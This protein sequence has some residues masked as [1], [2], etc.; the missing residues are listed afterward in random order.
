MP[1]IIYHRPARVYPERL[2]SKEIQIVAPPSPTAMQ[3]GPMAWLAL[4]IPFLGSFS[5]IIFVLIYHNYLILIGAGLMIVAS[6]GGGILMN[7]QQRRLQKRQ[8]AQQ[9]QRYK[10]YID[11]NK[12]E[13]VDLVQRQRATQYRLHPPP[14]ELVSVINRREQLWERRYNDEDFLNI[15]IGTGV[16]PLCQPLRLDTGSNPMAEF[17][18]ELLNQARQLVASYENIQNMPISIPLRSLGVLAISGNRT[19]THPLTRAM[20][21]QI[22]TFA[23][24]EDA[25]ILMYFSKDDNQEWEWLKWLPHTRRLNQVKQEHRNKATPLCMLAHNTDDFRQLLETQVVPEIDRRRKLMGGNNNTEVA[26][27]RPHFI[28][29][30]DD[31]TAGGPVG[32]ISALSDMLR[33][34]SHLGVSLIYLVPDRSDEPAFVQGRIMVTAAGW[35]TYS[36]AAYGGEVKDF[37]QPDTLTPAAGTDV[38]RA[39]TPI[40]L[41]DQRNQQDLAREVR[42]LDLLNIE[43]PDTL[44]SGFNWQPHSRQDVLR[45]PIGMSA[46]G[47]PLMLDIKESAEGGMGPHGLIIGATGSGKSELLRSIVMSL[48]L[49]HD[50]ETVNFVLADFKGGAS[51]AE[52]A[53]LPHTA[54]LITNLQN[55]PTLIDRMKAALFGEL[56]RRQQLLRDAGNLANIRQYHLKRSQEPKLAPLPYLMIIV[57]E[58]AELLTSRPDF[59]E[60][61]IAIGR[62]GR[63]L[64]ISMLLATQRL[65]EGRIQGLEGHLRYRICLRTFN[66][67]ESTAVLG[68][69]DAFYLPSYPGIGYF[70]VDTSV[71]LLFKS[72]IISTPYIP[73]VKQSEQDEVVTIRQFTP[74]G[75]LKQIWPREDTKSLEQSNAVDELRTV[76]DVA[77]DALATQPSRS[78]VHQVWLSPLDTHITL[79]DVLKKSTQSVKTTSKDQPF[80][81]LRIPI[82]LLDLPAQQRQEPLILDFSGAGGHLALVGTLQSGKSVFLQT[83]MLSFALT[84]TPTD[85]QIYGIDY[86]GGALH[87]LEDLPHVGTICGRG[88]RDK[89][90]RTIRQVRSIIEERELLFRRDRIS[91]I[92]TYRARRKVGEYRDALFGD[93][94]LII[95]DIGQLQ[96][97]YEQFGQDIIELSTI[98]LTYG[99]HIIITANRWM[100]IK[101]KL[102]DSIGTRIEFR[103]NDPNETEFNKATATLLLQSPSGRGVIKGGSIFQTALPLLDSFTDREAIHT[104]A[105][106]IRSGWNATPAPPVRLLPF[107]IKD[108][109]IAP[110]KA[111]GVVIGIDEF[112]LQPVVIDPMVN[113]PH[114]LILGDS[115]VG[116]TNLMRLWLKGVSEHYTPQELLISVIDFRRN[117]L[118]ALDCPN[119][120]SY[121]C[122]PAMLKDLVEKNRAI[123][124][125]RMLTSATITLETVR[126][127]RGFSGP[128]ILILVDDYDSVVSGSTNPLSP[129][130]EAIAQSR[131]VGLHV[132]IARKVSGMSRSSFEAGLQRIREAGCSGLIMSGDPQEGPLMGNQRAAVLPPGRGYLVRRNTPTMLIQTLL[133]T[134]TIEV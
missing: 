29:I 104:I 52:F 51:F 14:G 30:I 108:T 19:I 42:L 129:L 32:R 17:E 99:V 123:L 107:L 41:G 72:S 130:F 86:G 38:A 54:G 105:K 131:D 16:V 106:Y 109:D 125:P 4:I 103:L 5:S 21:G 64:G 31:F 35:I 36:E 82:G 8:I 120:L 91:S 20:I 133:S 40:S 98:G 112:L 45:F 18:P 27:Y 11:G 33:E 127:K 63:S 113:D 85:V 67:T 44:G 56:E 70:K 28:I 68:S 37:I 111:R 93:V 77:I 26:F 90:A 65:G 118:D 88:D 2:P 100:D 12:K 48:A 102:R 81:T 25:R 7:T 15:R 87:A 114:F 13:F 60:L 94:F 124:E 119:L 66:A 110:T 23:S 128:H 69:A 73:I 89:I 50:P 55:D 80:G 34:A 10:N 132:V 58:F 83:L 74:T 78:P 24:P 101:P 22:V 122:T 9:R 71:Y 59:L 49:T 57:D 121:A 75:S 46:D 43:S 96:G 47:E 117:L 95:D 61:F 134:Q 79:E 115:E 116:K 76:M 62:L 92:A 97:E 53:R 6:V 84:H 3:Q 39:L 1:G 126:S